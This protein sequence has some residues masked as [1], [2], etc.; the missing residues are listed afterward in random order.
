MF[1]NSFK[2]LSYALLLIVFLSMKATAT[3][4]VVAITHDFG[5][6]AKSVGGDLVDVKVLMNKSM[7]MHAVYPKPS[8]VHKVRKAD[9][10]IRVGLDQDSWI[11]SL[12]N[13]SRNR[14]LFMGQP[15]HL[16]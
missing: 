15:G 14:K 7:D 6:I 13:V 12:V 8:M 2:V 4:K 10:I 9:L 16:N 1:F 11:D 5:S 3:L